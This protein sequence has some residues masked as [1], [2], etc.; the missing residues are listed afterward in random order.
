[1]KVEEMIK[2]LEAMGFK[3]TSRHRSDGGMIITKINNMTFTGASGNQYARKV[4]GVELSQARIEQTQY[5]VQKFIKGAT[6]KKAL[7][8]DMKKELKRVQRQWRKKGVKGQVTAKKVKQHIAES[9]KEE[10]KAYLGKMERYGQGLAYESNVEWLA[11]YTEDRARGYLI[12]DEIQNKLFDL[13]EFIRS[14]KETFKEAWI[15]EVYHLLY[16]I[17]EDSF[18]KAKVED[19]INKIYYIIQ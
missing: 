2:Q 16:E 17:L 5:N 13:A 12:D 19:N 10:A 1:M 8:E 11:K 6:K 4:L 14:K 18:N 15:S 9:G 3:V 7:D